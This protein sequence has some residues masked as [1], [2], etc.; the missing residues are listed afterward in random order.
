[1]TPLRLL[2][3]CASVILIQPLRSSAQ[4]EPGTNALFRKENLA[5][6]C[7]VPF[8]AKKRG[9]EERAAMLEKMG[10][11]KLVY[12]YRPEHIPQWEEELKALQKHGI[13]LLGWWFP[14]TLND[15]AKKALGLF[16]QHGA[17]PQLWVT[18]NG[19]PIAV[20]D[21]A[22]QQSRV[23]KEVER[24][25]PIAQAAAEIG[26]RVALYNHG[27]WYGE[28]ENAL[29][30]VEALRAQGSKNVGL[31]YNLHHGHGH[32]SRLQ[33]LLPRLVPHLLCFNLNG[34]D[35]DGDAK[36]RKILPL[37]VGSEDVRVLKTLRASGYS[38][39][40]GILNH[41]SE[42]A[43]GRLLDNL[44]GLN[45]LL[46]QLDGKTAVPK[47]HYR[48][49]TEQTGT[50]RPAA[51]SAASGVA[52]LS[53]EFGKALSGGLLVDGKQ[54]YHTAPF[55]VECRAKLNGKTRFNIL[56]ACN[57]K[58]AS[59]HWELYTHTG[60][61][62]AAVYLPGRGGDYESNVDVCDGQ[63]HDFLVSI[64][65]AQLT[66]W[67]DGKVVL[68]KPLPAASQARPAAVESLAFG[69]LVE[70][71][72]GCEGLVDDVR[73]S[74][75]VM[76]PR[77]SDQ[78]RLRMDNTMGLWSFDDLGTQAA[79]VPA[80]TPSAF[81]PER[82]PLRREDCRHW[83]EFV[84]RDRIFDYYAKQAQSFMRQKP[85][86]ELLPAF[87]GLDGGKQGH[88]G[89]QNDQTTWKDGRFAGADHGSVFSTAFKGAGVTVPKG[90]C[91]RFD[92]KAAV[93]DPETLTFPV[94]WTG[95]FIKLSDARHGFMGGG[96]MEGKLLKKTTSAPRE[97]GAVYHGF[98]RHGQEV[99]FSFTVQGEKRLVT[100]RQDGKDL[101]A[102]TNGGPAQWPQWLETKGALGGEEPFATDTIT[103]PFENP[104]GTLFFLTGHDFFRDGTAAVSTM[105]GEVWLVRGID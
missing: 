43:E 98:Y 56:V 26:C 65:V 77:R 3:L 48:T 82:P 85:M 55:T 40:I 8:D 9:P 19:G 66:L 33:A 100:A 36:G 10:V 67:I 95:G 73:L 81:S 62:T 39:P 20:K 31:V 21:A 64:D 76:K 17:T 59:S 91:V 2:A 37:G 5:A 103:L 88:W 70:G 25:R 34:M 104:Y 11:R 101:A 74:R 7:I 51:P 105:T 90:V 63:W 60:R 4:T 38:G 24:L 41:T 57:P 18:G 102:L 28:P 69:R 45:W 52:S 97:T 53:P 23:A 46:P 75:G 80:P 42:D 32:L 72:L 96:Q 83:Q 15:E 87:P 27:S 14:A 54:D 78:P 84:N 58:S 12:D 79:T 44:D 99:I 49:W 86:P 47:P 13:A 93:F 61:G 94:T 89:N 16:R 35:V 29:A 68:E 22:D 92:D 6:W 30:I 50:A 71:T 1:M